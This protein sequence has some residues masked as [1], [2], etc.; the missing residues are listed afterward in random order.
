MSEHWSWRWP[1]AWAW[2]ERHSECER[3][4]GESEQKAKEGSKIVVIT[5]ISLGLGASRN[6]D[7]NKDGRMC[8]AS[9]PASY[10]VSIPK[11]SANVP[12]PFFTLSVSR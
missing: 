3:D 9:T 12:N 11:L 7:R 1:K 5:D 10:L 4:P 6:D 2:F 8:L